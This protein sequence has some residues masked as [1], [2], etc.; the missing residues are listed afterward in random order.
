M[1]SFITGD[2]LTLQYINITVLETI[3]SRV[4][5]TRRG[6]FLIFENTPQIFFEPPVYQSL[7]NFQIYYS[8]KS[9]FSRVATIVEPLFIDIAAKRSRRYNCFIVVGYYLEKV[10]MITIVQFHIRHCTIVIMTTFSK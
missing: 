1:G 8:E 2:Y 5:N 3:Y 9:Y 10:V 7:R 4:P 6:H